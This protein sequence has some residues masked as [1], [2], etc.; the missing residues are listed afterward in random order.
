M[1]LASKIQQ[2]LKLRAKKQGGFRIA[3]QKTYEESIIIAL[4]D[5]RFAVT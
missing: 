2:E 5:S 1:A 3:T 4:T